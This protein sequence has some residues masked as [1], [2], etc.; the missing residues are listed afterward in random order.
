MSH[1]LS[2]SVSGVIDLPYSIGSF[3]VAIRMCSCVTQTIQINPLNPPPLSAAFHPNFFKDLSAHT[4][5]ICSPC[6]SICPHTPPKQLCQVHIQLLGCTTIP[7]FSQQHLTQL[8][9]PPFLK[10]C[11]FLGSLWSSSCLSGQ[12]SPHCRA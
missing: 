9:I 12:F 4:I 7:L 1:H 6:F 3:P 11:P 8:I 5:S 2:V 10:H